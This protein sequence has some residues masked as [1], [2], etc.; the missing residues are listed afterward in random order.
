MAPSLVK[1]CRKKPAA[2]VFSG[3]SHKIHEMVPKV[4]EWLQ[5][6]ESGA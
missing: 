5:V 4:K 1:E 6:P 2:E 3:P